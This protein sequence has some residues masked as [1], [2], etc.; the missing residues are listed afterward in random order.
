MR[1]NRDNSE[2]VGFAGVM[3]LSFDSKAKISWQKIKGI[4]WMSVIRVINGAF[5]AQV[6]SSDIATFQIKNS[7][8]HLNSEFTL[9]IIYQTD[10]YFFLLL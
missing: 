3:V 1:I 6:V 10:V 2:P 8:L 4:I 9:L 7:F 5:R